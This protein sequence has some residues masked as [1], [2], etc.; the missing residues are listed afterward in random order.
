VE[1]GDVAGVDWVQDHHG[2]PLPEGAADA[3][4][5]FVDADVAAVVELDGGEDPGDDG[6]PGDDVAGAHAALDDTGGGA[7]GFGTGSVES[8]CPS[9]N[10][11]VSSH[12]A[13][14]PGP[15]G[16]VSAAGLIP[17]GIGHWD[18]GRGRVAD[19]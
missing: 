11:P 13:T 15:V 1:T 14:T 16:W 18:V 4:G 12:R 7:G 5:G 10:V 8:E 17:V 6:V 19:T 3:G 2:A 9:Q